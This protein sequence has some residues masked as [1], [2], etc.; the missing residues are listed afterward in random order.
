MQQFLI[1]HGWTHNP[2]KGA[3]Q[4]QLPSFPAAWYRLRDAYDV[5]VADSR[6]PASIAASA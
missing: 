6:K 5:A 3:W 4:W 1:A 2:A